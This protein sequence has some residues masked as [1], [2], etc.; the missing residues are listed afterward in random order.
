MDHTHREENDHVR[1]RHLA[2]SQYVDE[3][4]AI[5]SAQAKHHPKLLTEELKYGILGKQKY[6]VKPIPRWNE[7]RKEMSA[8][9][10]FGIYGLI[11]FQRPM[12]WPRSVVGQCELLPKRKRCE[13]ADR[14][15]QRFRLLQEVNNIKVIDEQRKEERKLTDEER[16]LLLE[17]LSQK[18]EMKFDAIL[19]ELQKVPSFPASEH[20]RLNLQAGKRTKM[21]GAPVDVWVAKVL[22]KT[23][24]KRPEEEK[25]G[26]VRLLLEH[27]HDDDECIRRLQKEWNLSMKETEELT[28]LALPQGY[29]NLSLEA[30]E[31]LLPHMEHGLI[32]MTDDDTPSALAAA[33]FERPDQLRRWVFGKLPNEF[34]WRDSPLGD[35]PNPVVRRTLVELRKVVNAIIGKYGRPAEVR[36]EMA[37]D[38]SPRPKPGTEAF[39]KYQ[40]RIERMRELEEAHDI[41]EEWLRERGKIPNRENRIRYLLWKEQGEICVYS[42]KP[43]SPQHLFGGEVDIDHILPRSKTLDDSQMNKVVCFRKTT[44][45]LGNQDKGQRTPYEWLAG[46]RPNVYE[47][48]CQRAS[49]LPYP[50]YRRFL[51][52]ELNRDDFVARQL[53][54]TRYIAKAAAEYLRCLFDF[55]ERKRGAVL[56]LKGQLTS[57]LRWQWGLETI[58][59]ELPDSPA[60]HEADSGKLRPGEKNRADHRH[61]AIDAVVIAL[62]NRSRLIQLSDI[63]KRGG[64]RTHGEILE[65]PWPNF[66]DGVVQ[67]IKKTNVSHRVER[68]VAGK[69]HDDTLY[70]PTDT[71]GEWVLRKPVIALSANEVERIRDPKIQQIVVDALANTGIDVGR[72]KKPDAK[73]MKEAL[74]TLKMPS[75]VPIKK[76]R[77]TKPEL[78]IQPVRAGRPDQAYV[79]PGST[80]HL[81][82]FEFTENGKTKRDAVFVT[83]LE[84]MNRLKRHEPIIQ[85]THPER[86]DARFN[87]SLAA[88]E[89]MQLGLDGVQRLVRMRT[90]VSTEKK[91]SFCLVEDA[92]KEYREINANMNT[93]FSKY[94]ARKVTVDPL[95]RIRWAND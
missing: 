22:G 30:I 80:H 51:T 50:K 2:R 11:F 43:I 54:D 16:T 72:G 32:Y 9:D 13:R 59:E 47:Q 7:Q 52:K 55:D 37:R 79:K 14:R 78:T 85:R 33:G 31:R 21:Q 57:E 82:I 12:Y 75:G 45:Q 6:P 40:A 87:L 81:C 86:P 8:L 88:G 65:D 23:W 5:W 28:S 27:Q 56:G 77:L 34:Q 93:L 73:K 26:I 18:E 35:I 29:V 92:R 41:A 63:V 60:W 58:L 15:A 67:A 39:R 70:G 36:V 68:K 25:N 94:D 20:V 1:N 38:M 44:D 83:M 48:V 66:R 84:A 69:L 76:V 64:A 46:E 91:M 10:S 95:G 3:F 90:S 24:H 53:N 42:G 71:P 61:H 19:K 49:S 4:E 62:T 17:K 74:S 89:I